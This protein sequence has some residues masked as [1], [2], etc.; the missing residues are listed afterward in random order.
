MTGLEKSPIN[1]LGCR[2]FT[3]SVMLSKFRDIAQVD[4]DRAYDKFSVSAR[5]CP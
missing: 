2:L 1:M 4:L 5:K 3:L